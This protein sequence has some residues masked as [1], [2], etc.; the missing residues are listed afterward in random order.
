M[1][2]NATF[3]DADGRYFQELDGNCIS[4]NKE[5]VLIVC[6]LLECPKELNGTVQVDWVRTSSPGLAIAVR[7]FG[8]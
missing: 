4:L 5:L 7:K 8:F 2:A 1:S 6:A 3:N